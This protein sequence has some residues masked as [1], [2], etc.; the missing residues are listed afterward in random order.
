MVPRHA[1]AGRVQPIASGTFDESDFAAEVASWLDGRG[2]E[3]LA[4]VELWR[5]GE[6][7]PTKA[8]DVNEQSE[9]TQLISSMVQK[10]QRDADAFRGD[11]QIY[12]F[13]AFFGV[14]ARAPLESYSAS[15]TGQYL[16]P[17]QSGRSFP[18]SPEGTLALAMQHAD[19]S[20]AMMLSGFKVAFDSQQ[21]QIRS[22]TAQLGE[23]SGREKEAM[24]LYAELLTADRD[25]KRQER[26]DA[27][28]E[29]RWNQVWKLLSVMLPSAV[30][31][32][33]GVKVLPE[34]TT[35]LLEEFRH[36]FDTLDA[37]QVDAF[38]AAMT[39][40][41]GIAFADILN[42][43]LDD[44]DRKGALANIL[45]LA[46]QAK[47]AKADAIGQQ[48]LLTAVATVSPSKD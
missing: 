5:N 19:A 34:V 43:F 17:Q 22:L 20:T 3:P 21:Y 13:R 11:P 30:N 2:G 26:A 15:L 46:Q 37:K 31:K 47:K 25:I 38:T 40:D 41:Q 16:A 27:A 28:S 29:E 23:L 39:I 4:C 45:A 36:F 32:I 44:K 7:H 8:W 35:P 24:K 48:P 14:G 6:P 10:A 12:T 42:K 1:N 18:A 33:T 9:A